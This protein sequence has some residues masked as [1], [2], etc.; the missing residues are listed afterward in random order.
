MDKKSPTPE[1]Y[2]AILARLKGDVRASRS[3]AALAVNREFVGLN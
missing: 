1:S 3:R 2:S